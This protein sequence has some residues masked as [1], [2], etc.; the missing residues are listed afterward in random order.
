[1]KIKKEEVDQ[2]KNSIQEVTRWNDSV[3]EKMGLV[4]IVC[5]NYKVKVK[6]KRVGNEEGVRPSRK[7]KTRGMQRKEE[8]ILA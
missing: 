1:M 8:A 4:E 6:E 2:A 3:E 7:Y 5:Q